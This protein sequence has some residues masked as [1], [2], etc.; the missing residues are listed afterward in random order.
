[1]IAQSMA[2]GLHDLR[3]DPQMDLLWWSIFYLVVPSHPM[4]LFW[5]FGFSG[6]FNP[7]D[8]LLAGDQFGQ[9]RKSLGRE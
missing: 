7:Q 5:F 9:R 2:C 8:R 6:A 1:M 3:R 4:F